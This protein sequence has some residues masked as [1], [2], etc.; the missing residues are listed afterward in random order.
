M[1]AGLET[2]IADFI[3]Y[4]K[5]AGGGSKRKLAEKILAAIQ[6][7]GYDMSQITPEMLQLVGEYQPEVYDAIIAQKPE[8]VTE[9]P[10]MRQRQ[11]GA[12]NQIQPYMQGQLPLQARLQAEDIQRAM[13]Q[14]NQRGTQYALESMAAQGRLGGGQEAT[15]RGMAGQNAMELA[16]SQGN[17]LTNTAINQQLQAILAGGQMAGGI[18][19]QDVNT[20]LANQDA[21]NRFNQWASQLQSASAQY[22]AAQRQAM[23]AQTL[24]ERQRISDVNTQNVQGT[25]TENLER[26]NRLLNQ[27][28]QDQMQKALAQSNQLMGASGQQMQANTNQA[29]ILRSA[30]SGLNEFGKMLTK[31]LGQIGMGAGGGGLG[32]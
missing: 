32:G 14:E 22:N 21:M 28:Y 4:G 15:L 23:G 6:T 30:G 2:A 11:V 31:Y 13:S 18:R 29:D 19:G 24:G 25:A 10:A 7:P 27:G 3:S 16:R 20:Q 8:L 12:M 26:K 17:A 5:G 9:D 1:G